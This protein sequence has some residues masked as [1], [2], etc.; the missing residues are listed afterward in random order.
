[1]EKERVESL[2]LEEKR[3]LDTNAEVYESALRDTAESMNRIRVIR[4]FEREAVD[5]YNQAVILRGE[6]NKAAATAKSESFASKQKQAIA[7]QARMYKET[8][9]VSREIPE[10]LAK[11]T[12][13][14]SVLHRDWNKSLEYSAGYCHSIAQNML[15]HM[16]EANYEEQRSFCQAFTRKRLLRVFPSWK[17]SLHMA[18]LINLS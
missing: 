5:T 13:I 11:L 4:Q 12:M 10:S 9:D 15:L 6:A 2:A 7:Q 1:M 3:R 18:S 8:M 14:H 17:V 16:V